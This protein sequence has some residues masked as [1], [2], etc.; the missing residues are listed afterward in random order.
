MVGAQGDGQLL[1]LAELTEGLG[2]DVRTD[3]VVLEDRRLI[4][5]GRLEAILAEL[6]PL[7]RREE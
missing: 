1:A 7:L 4:L 5:T 6:L 3:S 2:D